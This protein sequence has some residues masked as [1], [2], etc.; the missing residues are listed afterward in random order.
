MSPGIL[1]IFGVAFGAANSPAAQW[2]RDRG[3]TTF[4]GIGLT[5]ASSPCQQGQMNYRAY[6][7]KMDGNMHL[8]G[9]TRRAA[10]EWQ[11]RFAAA[12]RT[13]ARLIP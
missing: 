13:K 6:R 2:F 12:A 5:K 9:L 1:A 4:A 7:K 3:S 10:F 11:V 8:R